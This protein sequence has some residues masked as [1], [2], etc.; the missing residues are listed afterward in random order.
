V[1]R[2]ILAVA[3]YVLFGLVVFLG[4]LAWRFP[5]E[6]LGARLLERYGRIAGYELH[7]ARVAPSLLPPGLILGPG[8]VTQ[9]DAPFPL[10]EFSSLTLDPSLW[11]LVTGS[12]SGALLAELYGG[13]L[14]LVV[15]QEE[16]EAAGSVQG[17]D[18]DGQ[19]AG[20]GEAGQ[21][22]GGPAGPVLVLDVSLK[23]VDV[24]RH[25]ALEH[26]L[27]AEVTGVVTAD[28][29]ARVPRSGLASAAAVPPGARG[30]G[31]LLIENLSVPVSNPFL[32]VDRLDIGRVVA[33][34]VIRG[35]ALQITRAT[36]ASDSLEGEVSGLLR[37]GPTASRTFVKITGK[38][39]V[40]PVIIDMEAVGND[41][42]RSIL[43]KRTP[44]PL[45]VSG[46]L[47]DL[48]IA[49]F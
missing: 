49:G 16:G 32:K 19:E 33:D 37:P 26:L 41:T 9:A 10:L 38:I 40:A 42:V 5:W 34:F 7:A 4:L 12:P 35:P 13:E 48:Q 15:D 20:Q 1:R 31:S 27:G 22:V 47:D 36:F 39:S 2:R 18:Q 14:D 23:G 11:G 8:R 25:P 44:L 43:E 3:G 21:Q 28:V 29:S 30:T 45:S 17:P 6:A 24:A 46:P